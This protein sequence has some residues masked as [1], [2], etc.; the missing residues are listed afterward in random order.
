MSEKQQLQKL[1]RKTYLS[2]HQDGLVDLL[3]GWMIIAFGANMATDSST[4]TLFA[5]LPILFYVPLKNRIT[6]PRL[7]YVKFDTSRGYGHQRRVVGILVLGLLVLM[8]VGI[9]AFLLLEQGP[10]PA[11]SWLRNNFLTFI[12]LIGF[13]GFGLGA[14]FSG[15]TRFYA[16]ALLSIVLMAGAER[17]GLWD[18]LPFFILGITIFLTG[19]GLLIRFLRRYPVISE[20]A[21]HA[22]D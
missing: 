13:V 5:W 17:L 2:Y 14:R 16:Y 7:G 10:G 9:L 11:V 18:P 6:V 12:G 22:A 1:E 20:S 3:I 15:V 21:N 4:W 8:V 19:T